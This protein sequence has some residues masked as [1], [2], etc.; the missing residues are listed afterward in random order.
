MPEEIKS[1][2]MP[3]KLIW[4]YILSIAVYFVQGIEGVVGLPL[5]AF[6]KEQCQLT[7]QK[8]MYI[9]SIIT[10]PWLIKPVFGLIID[11]Y[12]TAKVWIIFSLL[13]SIVISLLF[14]LLYVSIPLIILLAT[15]SSYFTSIRDISNDGI[16]CIEGKASNTCDI[17][18]NCQW[19][20]IT[21]ASIVTSLSGGFIAQYFNYKLAYLCLIPIYVLILLIVSKYRTVVPKN[22]TP[23]LKHIIAYK[24]LFTNRTF[25]LG[26]LFIFLFN[27][28]PS[29][30]TPLQFIER[31]TFHWSWKFM[32][33]IGAV[34]SGVSILGSIIYYK[35]SK[36]LNIE[37]ILYWS[38]F[39]G[40]GTS[41]CYLFFTPISA[42]VYSIIFSV[43]GMFIFLNFMTFMARSTLTGKEVTS[44]A[45][46]CSISNLANTASTLSGAFLF[47]LIG[48]KYLIIIS[49]VTSFLCLPIITK[50][51]I[52]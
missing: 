11:R 48:L 52:K 2:L 51:K 15:I 30:G 25:M 34:S 5:F 9:S 24:E 12:F 3:R 38:V 10:I 42:I 41:L 29:F 36:R 27:F 39:I 22:S 47:P 14:N 33:I 45:L 31:D 19:T 43:I 40:A 32:G 21:I 49:A 7:P 28:N 44:F 50:L 26:C 17:F 13:G 4:L 6:L 35:Y 16:A 18:Q 23:F 1:K 37:K 8:I 20:A 46:L